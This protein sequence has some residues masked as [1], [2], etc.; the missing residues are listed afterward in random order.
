MAPS[1]SKVARARVVGALIAVACASLVLSACGEGNTTTATGANPGD[2]KQ[3]FADMDCGSCH[4]YAPAGSSGTRGPALDNIVLNRD[5]IIEQI[6]GGGGGMPSYAT[7]L[8]DQQLEALAQFVG[9]G[10]TIN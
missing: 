2:G 3:I 7:D 10:G 4:T 5:Q 9:E 6:Q 1:H 8:N